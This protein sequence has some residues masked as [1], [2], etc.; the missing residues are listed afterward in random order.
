MAQLVKHLTLGFGSGHD[1]TVPEFELCVGPVLTVQS[2]LGFLS[3]F[4]FLPPLLLSFSLSQNK[5]IN[6][7]LKNFFSVLSFMTFVNTYFLSFLLFSPNCMFKLS[8]NPS[9]QFFASVILTYNIYHLNHFQA[10]SSA[11]LNILALL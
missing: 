3:L 2:L 1:L 9:T 10:Y 5:E 7:K 6:L 4:P 11:V 8:L